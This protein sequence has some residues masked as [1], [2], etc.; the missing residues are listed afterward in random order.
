MNQHSFPGAARQTSSKHALPEFPATD[1]EVAGS[2]PQGDPSRDDEMIMSQVQAGQVGRLAFLFERH[3]LHLFHFFRQ[4]TQEIPAS[5][6]LVQEVFHRILRHRASYQL[7]APFLPW[8]WRI[9]RNA[10]EDY[11]KRL[12]HHA[13][14]DGLQ[15]VLPHDGD[16]ADDLALLAE[17]L[18]RLDRAL[19]Q[20]AP[21]KR[22]LLL[23]TRQTE[24]SYAEIA[25]L[26]DCSVSALKSQVHR[27]LRELREHFFS[28]QGGR[29]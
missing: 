29:R 12:K 6:D 21:E 1:A 7:G 25:D 22:E 19:S 17:D 26:M 11:R 18:E 5:E 15:E 16:R 2:H 14:L 4:M 27:A 9:A 24:L 20:L 23:I 10:Y 8:M 13:S 3:K 28:L